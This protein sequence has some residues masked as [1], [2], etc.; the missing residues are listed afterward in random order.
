MKNRN[1]D[2]PKAV[3]KA[4]VY[5]LGKT[6]WMLLARIDEGQAY[7]IWKNNPEKVLWRLKS[8]HDMPQDWKDIIRRCVC[9]D[10]NNRI[11]LKE[12]SD[13]WEMTERRLEKER[14]YWEKMERT[15]KTE[16]MEGIIMGLESVA[17]L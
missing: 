16:E 2:C 11:D 1:H 3:E 17:L 10:P 13:F 9:E 4:E 15:L 7:H 14:E 6:M 8:Q 12:L 5:A